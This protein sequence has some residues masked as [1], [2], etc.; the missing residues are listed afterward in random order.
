[1][2]VTISI[3]FGLAMRYTSAAPHVTVSAFQLFEWANWWPPSEL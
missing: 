2:T 3:S 1:L